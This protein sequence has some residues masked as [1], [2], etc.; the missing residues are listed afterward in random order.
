M[1]CY[2]CCNVA[3]TNEN[4]S[5]GD[6]WRAF[7][8]TC[9]EDDSDDTSFAIINTTEGSY[10]DEGTPNNLEQDYHDASIEHATV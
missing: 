5:L 10:F 4:Y 1:R 9:D 7:S 6:L 2:L 3:L 8:E